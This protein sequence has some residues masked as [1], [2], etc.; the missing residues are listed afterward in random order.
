MALLFSGDPVTGKQCYASR[1]VTSRTVRGGKRD[2]QRILNEVV[3]EAAQC[4]SVRTNATAGELIEAWFEHA[5][6]DFSPKTVRETRGFIDRNLL[7]AIAG[8]HAPACDGASVGD[9]AFEDA[10]ARDYPVLLGLGVGCLSGIAPAVTMRSCS[11]P[12]SS[13]RL[14]LRLSL[15]GGWS[16]SRLP[17]G[18]LSSQ[19]RTT[20][21]ATSARCPSRS[22]TR[23]PARHWAASSPG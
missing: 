21:L 18:V 10:L 1:T 11:R 4:L 7:P 6:G 13:L 14:R 20:S 2:A 17:F 12:Y 22:R 23:S 9:P 19:D 15:A 3:S 16:P 8:E 5:A